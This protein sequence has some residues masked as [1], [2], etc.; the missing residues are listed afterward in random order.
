VVAVDRP[1]IELASQPYTARL[2]AAG[3]RRAELM[4]LLAAAPARAKTDELR[5][6]VVRENATGKGS[7]ASR[8]KVWEQLRRKYVLDPEVPEY[9]ALLEAFG[10]TRS[11]ADQ[12]LLCYLLF[13][14]TDRL[15]RE[16]VSEGV[17]PQLGR[18][19]TPI[20]TT[21]VQEILRAKLVAQG[22]EWSEETLVTARQHLLSALK[23]FGVLRGGTKK[24]TVKPRPGPIVVWYAARLAQLEG[25]TAWQ[26]PDSIWFR[27]LGLERDAAIEAL[28]EA[29]RAGVLSFR[30][31]A[32][33]IELDLHPSV[34]QQST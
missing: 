3:S 11:Y 2:A 4:A 14:R 19:G 29:T 12:G 20:D 1:A 18:D 9:R 26:V 30:Q 28:R 7:A 21:A 13:A 15:F 5:Q 6:L 25:R 22:V 32:E 27:L 24:R 10:A 34:E 23:D 16:G 8:A 31:Q 33:V 17:V